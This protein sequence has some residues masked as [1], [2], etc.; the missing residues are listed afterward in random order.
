MH[1]VVG[2]TGVVGLGAAICHQLRDAGKPTRA[3]VRPTA[4]PQRVADLRNIG[5]DVVAGDLKDPGSLRRA[6][7]GIDTV[8]STASIMASHQP[9]DTV[10]NVDAGGQ[11]SLVAAAVA[12][13]VRSFVYVSFSAHI[14][15]DFP[16]RNAKRAVERRLMESGLKWT[17]LRPTFYMEVWL[18]PVGGFDFPNARA[19]IFGEGK[20][21]I[22]WISFHDVARFAAICIGS[23]SAG[24]RAFELGGPEALSPRSVVQLF[25]QLEGRPF[26]IECI[27]ADALA[28]QQ[29]SSHDSLEQS[30]AGLRR[31]Y[32]DGDVIDMGQPLAEFLMALTSVR[33]YAERV[34]HHV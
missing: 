6:C 2:A 5:V 28:E 31:C 22:S 8:I 26:Q 10:E 4:S 15:R 34:L 30:L 12:A 29:A 19:T 1:L 33:D 25:E 16:F 9:G 17:I 20:N 23:P 13:G 14:D 11:E 7:E 18:S 24:S 27:S 3:V 32:A 21:P